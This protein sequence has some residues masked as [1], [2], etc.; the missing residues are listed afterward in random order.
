VRLL[1]YED[2]V[3]AILGSVRPGGRLEEV[4]LGAALGRVSSQSIRGAA[5]FPAFDNSAVDGYAVSE[6]TPAGSALQVWGEAAAGSGPQGAIAAGACVRI[7]TGGVAPANTFGIAM[8]ED[9]TIADGRATFLEAVEPEGH[10]RRRGSDYIAGDVLFAAGETF[11]PGAIALAATQGLGRLEV[12]KR[13][14]CAVITTGRELVGAEVEPGPGQVRDSNGPMLRALVEEA[15]AVCTASRRIGDNLEE[16][17]SEIAEAASASD[18]VILS[19]G[20]SVGDYDYAARA[21]GEIGEIEFHG[22]AVKPGKPLLFAHVGTCPVVALPGNPASSFVGFHLF[23]APAI[24]LLAG[25]S[26]PESFWVQVALDGDWESGNRDEFVRCRLTNTGGD[27]IAQPCA[28]QGSFAITSLSKAH[29]LVRV[30][31]GT[32]HK[33]GGRRSAL[34]LQR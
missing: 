31:M 27:T 10:I 29:A 21:I 33:S 9:V 5:D 22:V 14:N 26:R 28:A 7:L 12:F 3:A 24:R 18:L 6:P 30:P 25:M 16:T 17:R 1:S 13:V 34:I 8:Q 4:P 20:A 19:G 11:T 15:G 23:V 2:A 32:R